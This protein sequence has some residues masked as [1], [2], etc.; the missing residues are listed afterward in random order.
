MGEKKALEVLKHILSGFVDLLK[1]GII[2]RDLKPQNILIKNNIFKLC[3]FG[4]ARTV[5]IYIILCLNFYM[6]GNFNS[7][8]LN[9]SV[10]TPQYMSP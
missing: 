10:G 3:D 1:H 8:L 5:G 2:H 6:L 9:S 4:F 7:D